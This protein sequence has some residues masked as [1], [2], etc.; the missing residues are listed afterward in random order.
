MILDD[1]AVTPAALESG[2]GWSAKP[3]GL[4][5]GDLQHVSSSASSCCAPSVMT[6]RCPGGAKHTD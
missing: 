5:K 4:C 1:L 3:E 2:T 6:R